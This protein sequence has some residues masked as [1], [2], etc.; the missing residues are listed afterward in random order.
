MV[1]LV[2]YLVLMF[3]ALQYILLNTFSIFFYI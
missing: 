1:F 3:K 2:I